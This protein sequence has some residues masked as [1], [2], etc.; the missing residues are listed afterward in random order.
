MTI[1]LGPII[2]A[3]LGT[4]LYGFVPNGKVQE[5]WAHHVFRECFLPLHQGTP[6]DRI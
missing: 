1:S 5:I 4:M 6:T 3:V 2:L